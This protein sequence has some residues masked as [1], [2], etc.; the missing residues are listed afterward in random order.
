M[1][2]AGATLPTEYIDLVV[3]LPYSAASRRAKWRDLNFRIIRAHRNQVFAQLN[4]PGKVSVGGTVAAKRAADRCLALVARRLGPQFV[5][6][7]TTLNQKLKAVELKGVEPPS[8]DFVDPHVPITT[9]PVCIHPSARLGMV[10]DE[11]NR[12]VE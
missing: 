10:V 6:A 11:A 8:H 5:N 9:T 1:A 7:G 2:A 3:T 4:A 12:K